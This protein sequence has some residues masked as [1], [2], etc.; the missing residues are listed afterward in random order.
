M[1][2]A[3]QKQ[4]VAQHAISQRQ[5]RLVQYRHIHV[6]SPDRAGK[7]VHEAQTQVEIAVCRAVISQQDRTIHVAVGP[8]LAARI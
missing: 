5:R 6:V 8:T 3:E 1:V 2:A 7:A 4:T